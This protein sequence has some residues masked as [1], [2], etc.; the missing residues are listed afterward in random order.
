M[1]SDFVKRLSAWAVAHVK[2][3]QAGVQD[4]RAVGPH[5]GLFVDFDEQCPD[6]LVCTIT[7][8]TFFGSHDKTEHEHAVVVSQA[9][10]FGDLTG[11]ERSAIVDFSLLWSL[12]EARILHN[13]GNANSICAAVDGWRQAGTL[14]AE[15]YDQQLA[16]FRQRYF[17]NGA[18]THHF[19]HLY[20][21]L[22][23][24]VP[25]I[26]S[27]IDGSNNNQ[28][29][30]VATVFVVILRYRNNLF[31]GMKW[32]YQLAGQLDNFTNANC[33]LMTALEHHGQL[34]G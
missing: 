31:H 4:C 9:P 22:N 24:Q 13:A 18:F 20:L 28:S 16:Y 6:I 27:V 5:S 17:A 8:Y 3:A 26:R 19:D 11:E 29:H 14:Q 30:E 15:A 2:C 21:R 7:R 1:E 34:Q 23:D 12:F 33:A 10:G 25:L 32:Q